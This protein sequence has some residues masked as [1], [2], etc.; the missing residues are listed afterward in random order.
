MLSGLSFMST[1]VFSINSLILYGFP[2]T[3]FHLTEANL[4]P[5][6]ILKNLS[7]PLIAKRCTGIKVE[8]KPHY[9]LFVDVH[10]CVCSCPKI[11]PNDF[12]KKNFFSMLILQS[13]CF[14]CITWKHK[15]TMESP[16][17]WINEIKQK[18][19]KATSYSIWP[20]VLLF[21]GARKLCNGIIRGWLY[22]Q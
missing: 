19:S 5:R 9:L 4:V 20:S 21:D 2:L 17:I 16:S 14:I 22:C 11:S 7:L 13:T 3:S 10:S 8:L 1:F 18:Q 12:F 6:T 15:Q